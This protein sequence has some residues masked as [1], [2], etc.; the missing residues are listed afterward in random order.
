ML[1]TNIKYWAWEFLIPLALTLIDSL[2][3]WIALFTQ[4]LF[5]DHPARQLV[6]QH[7]SP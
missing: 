4:F 5:P 2:V 6:P 1:S 3:S 7:F